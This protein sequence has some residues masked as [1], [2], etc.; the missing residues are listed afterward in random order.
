M[1]YHINFLNCAQ[2]QNGAKFCTDKWCTNVAQ[3]NGAQMLHRM[4]Q[5]LFQKRAVFMSGQ[6]FKIGTLNKNG[7]TAPGIKN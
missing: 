4:V 1:F 3:K 7:S 5:N 2:K 6:I